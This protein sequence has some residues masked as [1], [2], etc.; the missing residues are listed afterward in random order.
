MCLEATELTLILG[1]AQIVYLAPVSPRPPVLPLPNL[2]PQQEIKSLPLQQ[3][4]EV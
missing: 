4:P 3:I 2:I 1:Q